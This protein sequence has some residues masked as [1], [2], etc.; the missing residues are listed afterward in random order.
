MSLRGTPTKQLRPA[1]GWHRVSSRAQFEAGGIDA[2]QQVCEEIAQRKGLFIKWTIDLPGITGTRVMDTKQV[3]RMRQIIEIEGCKDVLLKEPTRLMRPECYSDF[4]ILDFFREH[5]VLLHSERHTWDLNEESDRMY[6]GMEMQMSGAER[7]RIIERTYGERQR[8]RAAGGCAS[9][10]TGPNSTLPLEIGWNPKPTENDPDTRHPGHFFPVEPLAEQVRH[11][12]KLFTSGITGFRQLAKATGISYQRIGGILANSRFNGYNT[13]DS[14]V[15]PKLNVYKADDTLSYQVKVKLPEDQIQKIPMKGF[16]GRSKPH[17]YDVIIPDDVFAHAQSLLK[18][19]RDQD[20]REIL[21]PDN[22]PFLFR[23]FMRC[24]LCDRQILS[25]KQKRHYYVCRGAQGER[26]IDPKGG[27]YWFIPP[28]SCKSYRAAR[29]RMD[30]MLFKLVTGYIADPDFL[31]RLLNRRREQEGGA[32]V[33]RLR[34]S[35]IVQIA[36]EEESLARLNEMYEDRMYSKEQYKLKR[37]KRQ[38]KLDGLRNALNECVPQI[39]TVE[40]D[41]LEK[42]VKP[43]RG[44]DVMARSRQRRILTGICP[45]FKVSF[46]GNGGIGRAAKTTPVVH[47][48][49]LNLGGGAVAVSPAPTVR[50]VREA[51][52]SGNEWHSSVER[53]RW[54][55][56]RDRSS[57]R[58]AAR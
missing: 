54:Y 28:N 29:E 42:L 5:N 43:F 26:Q 49:Y 15:D 2:S 4:R 10:H 40:K 1:I 18:L 48:F 3:Q 11:L 41:Y 46:K 24:E 16:I 17:L 33:K 35:L 56:P 39:P 44:F 22:D 25:L 53:T 13:I 7:R 36:Q 52:N 30:E 51:Q 9:P 32:S 19:K 38:Q 31:I 58:L 55:R 12:F 34:E 50:R 23:S 47:G 21:D 57:G 6:F 8:I 27:S 37:A 14:K 45:L 20:A